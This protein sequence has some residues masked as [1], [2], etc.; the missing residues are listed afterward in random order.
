[1]SNT[2]APASP[3][4]IVLKSCRAAAV[5]LFLISGII[6][7]LMLTGSL[8]MMQVYDRVLGSQ[9]IS[10]LVLLSLMATAAFLFQGGLDIIRTRVLGL[11]GERIDEEVAPKVHEAVI[12]LPLR[13]KRSENEAMQ[14]FRDVDAIRSFVSGPGPVAMFDIPWMPIYLIFLFF[15]H[16]SLFAATVIG[17]LILIF[18]TWLTDFKSKAPNKTALEAQSIRNQTADASQRGAEALRAMGLRPVMAAR[19]QAKHVQYMAMQRRVTLVT[20]S[21][22][23]VSKTV[24]MILQSAMLGL[25]AYLAIKGEIS[26]GSIIAGTILSS[27][28]LAPIDQ[29]IGAWKGFISARQAHDRLAKLLGMYPAKPEVFALPAPTQS[30]SVENLVVGAPGGRAPIVKRAN[31]EVRAGQA[32]GV[33]GQSASGKTTLIRA[34]IGVWAPLNGRV[35]LDGASLDQWDPD[36]L[37]ASIGYLPQDVQLFDGTIAEN[38]AR[39]TEGASP[40]VVIAAAKAASFHDHVLA[41]PDGYN[42]RVGQGGTHLSAGQRQRLGL[43]RA[44]YNDPFLVVLDEPN[45]NL[46][47][48]GEASV[49]DAIKSVQARKG[50]AIVIAHRP[51]AVAAVDLILAMKNGETV[52]FGPRDEVFGKILKNANNVIK[53]PSAQRV[54]AVTAG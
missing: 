18:L 36:A 45:S 33:I 1:V 30:I 2:R 19:W 15:L 25:G 8:F 37:G 5:S 42:T 52:A 48:E 46:D 10:T 27:R 28:A 21:I 6:N 16:W 49:V 44:L 9:S 17:A 7:V 24:R 12:D 23:G 3:V 47:A 11:V 43:A 32:L 51:S 13:I 34:L 35:L 26:S 53:H 20:T 50:I 29:A 38:I 40:D 22:A 31:F 54:D 41:F 14:P 39:F 4:S